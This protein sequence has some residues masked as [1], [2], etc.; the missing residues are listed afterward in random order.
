[1]KIGN[2]CL[3][4]F[5][6]LLLIDCEIPVGRLNEVY[7]Y[8][9]NLWGEWIRMDTGKIWY[10]ASN[11]VNSGDYNP[12]Y[13]YT[14]VRQSDNVVKV[15][16]ESDN[17][18]RKVYYLYA[19]RIPNSS[20]SASILVNGKPLSAVS[21]NV[22]S[23]AAPGGIRAKV[24][25][26]KNPANSPQAT[27]DEN[28]ILQ[29]DDI[30]AGDEYDIIIG[31]DIVRVKPNND[32]EDVGSITL[33]NG[34]GLN[35]KAS[36]QGSSVDMDMMNLFIDQDYRLHINITNTGTVTA[37]YSTFFIANTDELTI[38]GAMT[39]ILGTI[40]PGRTYSL[41][42]TVHCPSVNEEFEFKKIG[43]RIQ[44]NSGQNLEWV[45]SVSV[46]FNK[47]N[48]HFRIR[49]MGIQGNNGSVNGIV[50]V[51]GGKAYHFTAS[52]TSLEQ[53]ITAVTVPRYAGKEY[54]IAFLGAAIE[55]ESLFSFK[56][57]E[58]PDLIPLDFTP[59][60]D[61]FYFMHD[62]ERNARSIEYTDQVMTFLG[63][64]DVI[65]FKVTFP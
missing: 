39:G 27:T 11:H 49:A 6:S 13:S 45:D 23:V 10:I 37:R 9:Q 28:G 51:P 42:L 24:P 30:I 16:E 8:P 62:T 20:F 56:I 48:A 3:V 40:D 57:D 47:S 5:F 54:L 22:R 12:S 25:N 4:L 26:I 50:I 63:A 31:D 7:L 53:S 34:E 33:I 58:D 61:Q 65:Y 36:V 59:A 44:D 18:S 29:V 14:L 60:P 32:G 52:G 15:T 2:V 21:F 1:M 35:F 41:P 17:V 38:D 55:S 46:K 19:S 64:D 43:I